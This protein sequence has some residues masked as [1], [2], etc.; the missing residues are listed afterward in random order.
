[1]ITFL[2]RWMNKLKRKGFFIYLALIIGLVA[3][4]M[5]GMSHLP[6]IPP[7]NPKPKR[8]LPETGHLVDT[9]DRPQLFRLLNQHR[10]YLLVDTP[11]EQVRLQA[12]QVLDG[13]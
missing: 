10:V 5:Y 8:R 7:K 1:M 11:I 2:D 12:K 9:L 13:V 6:D 3:Y 4:G